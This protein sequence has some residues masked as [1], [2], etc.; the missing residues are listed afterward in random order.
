MQRPALNSPASPS[1]PI[2]WMARNHVAANLIMLVIV[3]GGFIASTQVK[4]EVFPEFAID[5][6]VASVPY[7]G[8]S[9]AE[10]EQGVVLSIEDRVRGID[11]VK[12]VTATAREGHGSVVVE[13]LTGT[14]PDKALQDVK[15]A[16][17]SILS[18]PEEAEK[19]IVS[20]V[21]LRNQ[22]LTLMVYGDQD[23]HTLRDL[24]EQIRDE[25]IQRPDITLVG[26]GA[27]RPLE[28]AIEVPQRNLRAH[29][30]TLGQIAR[31]IRQA[32][33]EL[34][35]GGLKAAGGEILLR[36][37]ERRDYAS[38]YADIALTSAPDGSRITVGDIAVITDGFEDWD[39]EA[40]YNGQRAVQVQVYRVARETPQSVSAS[41]HAYLDDIRPRLPEGVGLTVWGDY[42]EIYRD[43]MRLLL[44]NAFLGLCLVLLL[45]GLF[46]DP[47]L[48]FWVTLGIPISIMGA[49]LFMPLSGASINMISLFAFIITL[50]I[51]VDDAVV[52][53]ENIYEK[54]Q[55]GRP[56]LA[57][58]IEGAQE[59]AGPI[60]FA[61][62]TNIVAFLPLVFVPGPAGKFFI[63][64]PAVTIAVFTVSLIESLFI[65]P[66]HLSRQNEP[67][68]L[69]RALNRPRLVFG[70]ALQAFVGRVYQPL[71]RT[72]IAHRYATLTTGIAALLLALGTVG[73]GHLQFSFMPRIDSDL[74]TAQATLPFG[75]PIDTSRRVRR[76]L[77]DAM[78]VAID[79]HGGPAVV[80][81]TYTQIGA[82]LR[83]MGP[84]DGPPKLSGGHLAGVQI[85]LVPS[86][87]REV[88]SVEFANTWRRAAS[89][90]AGLEALTFQAESGFS[91]EAALDIQLTHRSRQ[92]LEAAAAE[93]AGLLAGYAGVTDIDDGVSHGKPQLSLTVK[94]EARSLGINATDLARQ[95]RGSFYGAEA[96]RQQ[97]GRNEV[98]VMVRLPEHERRTAHTIEQMVIRT[99]QGGEIPLIQAAV[100]DYGRAYT[101]IRRREGRRIMAVTADV[102]ENVTNANTIVA[103]LE[104]NELPSLMQKYPG[105][106]YTLE[107]EQEWQ[108]E[109]LAAIGLGFVFALLAIYALLAIPFKSYIQPVIV[110]LAIPFGLIGAIIGHILLGYALSMISL[111]GIIALAGVVINDALVLVVTA[112]QFRDTEQTTPL[113][114]VCRAGMRRF[115][116][117]LLTSLTTFFGLMPMI[118]ETSMQARFLI[119]MAISIGF[120]ILFATAIILLI[121]PAGYMIL[122]D[123]RGLPR[124]LLT[125]VLRPADAAGA[126]SVPQ[127]D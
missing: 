61:V 100:V 33:V 95:L 36:T 75:T 22:V 113:E 39:F 50:G 30:L 16:V 92:V 31:E 122:E 102:D 63:N 91:S 41:V 15:N 55:A 58:A 110:M 107:G 28:I 99:P 45:L 8:A 17:D 83:G 18:F 2:A 72:A 93:L 37:Q 104:Q 27:V 112:N 117:I 32:A 125:G 127:P 94:P 21:E 69:W 88:N 70:R 53:G 23:E 5:I 4:Q 59:I 44:K 120:G 43:R 73:G 14:D 126:G 115:R 29:N 62:L 96:L 47:K 78:Q 60:I 85:A 65:L 101:E 51:I 105:L 13:L 40:F 12:K 90:I 20:L 7:P 121:V 67:G 98:K 46:L 116:P 108:Q 25:L 81:G 89:H 24:A 64:I 56:L 48:A 68:R 66:A 97:R 124:L 87:Q 80:R 86:D 10:V 3:V 84:D 9:P 71:L 6:I 26:L 123:L 76:Q 119:P 19:P 109:A 52:M 79:T 35:A 74:I 49:F 11:G 38:Q 77:L 82:V 42:S 1:G 54:R 118:F 111:F 57:A 114:A 34:P 106:N 103:G